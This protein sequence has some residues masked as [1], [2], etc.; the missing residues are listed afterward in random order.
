M[1][2]TSVRIEDNLKKRLDE[3]AKKSHHSKGWVINEALRDYLDRQDME[4][5][6]WQE[7]LEALDDVE[8]GRV[9]DGKEV[10]AWM[11]SWG[12]KGGKRPKAK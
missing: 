11:R 12:K 1:S 5:T 8:A 2:V 3:A 9:V 6:R 4:E 7:T 10:S